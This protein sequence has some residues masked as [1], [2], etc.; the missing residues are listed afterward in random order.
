MLAHCWVDR[1][2]IV[3]YCWTSQNTT[4]GIIWIFSS[5][6]SR[7]TI[8]G[9]KHDTHLHAWLIKANQLLTASRLWAVYIAGSTGMRT[10]AH[11]TKFHHQSL[12]SCRVTVS[13]WEPNRWSLLKQETSYHRQSHFS[14]E[15]VWMSRKK[16]WAARGLQIN[17]LYLCLHR[18]LVLQINESLSE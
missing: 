5:V 17:E 9:D 4:T 11:F 12:F 10:T 1:S 6:L 8:S 3:L 15:A 13:E 18:M 14:T 2:Y 16:L 7:R